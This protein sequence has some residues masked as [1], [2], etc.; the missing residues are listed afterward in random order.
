MAEDNLHSGPEELGGTPPEPGA[1]N[2]PAQPEPGDV[3]VDFDKINE[4][5]AQRRAAERA[6]VEAK[7]NTEPVVEG[8]P[9]EQSPQPGDDAPPCP[10]TMPPCRGSMVNPQRSLTLALRT[11]RAEWM[12]GSLGKRH[13]RS[14]R[15]K[16]PSP[17]AAA[18]PRRRNPGP[19]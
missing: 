19:R 6:K 9:L 8:N 18:R 17:S 3:V 1:D 5:M 16:S 13:W 4:L 2:G 14:W 15:R 10:L 7:E 12:T 11:I